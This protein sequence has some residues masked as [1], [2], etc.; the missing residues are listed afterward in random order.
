MG[1]R[2][3]AGWAHYCPGPIMVPNLGPPWAMMDPSVPRAHYVPN[4]GHPMGHDGP[5]FAQGP[6]WAHSEPW[7]A[8]T[9]PG[10]IM[11]PSVGPP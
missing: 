6:L 9:C 5:K 4:L 11:G 8:Q 2:I 3:A 1:P 7:R 10:P